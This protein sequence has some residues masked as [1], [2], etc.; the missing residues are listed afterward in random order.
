MSFAFAGYYFDSLTSRNG[1]SLPNTA[2]TVNIHGQLPVTKATL[3][4][5]RTK[6]ITVA[7]PVSTTALGN[8]AF[9]ADPGIYD[10][11]TPTG[12]T[13]TV[14]VTP[15]A[16]DLG[17]GGGGLVDS[18]FTRIGAVVAQAGDYNAA[19]VG[20]VDVTLVN[21]KGDLL[22][23]SADNTVVRVAVGS[24]GQVLTAA[25]GQP[26][27]VSWA[28]GGGGGSVSS[29]FTRTGAVVAQTGDYT[30]AQVGAQ[31]VD[32]TL[33]ALAGITSTAGLL[34]QTAADTLR[35]GHS[36]PAPRR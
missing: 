16:G 25:S 35:S 31:P 34:T 5:D 1:A 32:P 3:Y 30:P 17:G 7:N 13:V 33:T 4:T 9:Y 11:V 6:A 2:I 22:V 36:R 20:A 19:Q 28:A 15:D 18:V 10:L 12:Y 23:G 29:V 27:G 26:G 24:D 14:S 8:L 21:A